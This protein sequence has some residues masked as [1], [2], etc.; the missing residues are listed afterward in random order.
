[1]KLTPDRRLLAAGKFDE[2]QSYQANR[3]FISRDFVVAL[4]NH[5]IAA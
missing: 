3:L 1:M 5:R 2:W 4:V